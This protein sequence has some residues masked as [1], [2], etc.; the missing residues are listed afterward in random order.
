MENIACIIFWIF[1]SLEQDRSHF[2]TLSF[3]A[4]YSFTSILSV[5]MHLFHFLIISLIYLQVVKLDVILKV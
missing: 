5:Y 4:L 2:E 1:E 3:N